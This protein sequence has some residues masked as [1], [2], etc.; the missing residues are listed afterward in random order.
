MYP[1]YAG[2]SCSCIIYRR[3]VSPNCNYFCWAKKK[4]NNCFSSTVACKYTNLCQM[5]HSILGDLP[6]RYSWYYDMQTE[7][8]CTHTHTH[9]HKQ[10]HTHTHTHTQTHTHTHTHTHTQ[11]ASCCSGWVQGY[12][13]NQ[14]CSFIQP[15]LSLYSIS[16]LSLSVSLILPLAFFYLLVIQ[17]E[18][19]S[20]HTHRQN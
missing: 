3:S 8:T 18:F 10:T 15:S 20:A 19:T 17:V 2:W 4:K 1:I 13:Y 12:A 9:T 14:F 16:L 5:Y 7:W 6:L 11:H